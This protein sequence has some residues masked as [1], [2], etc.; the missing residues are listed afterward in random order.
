MKASQES[1]ISTSCSQFF[2][3]LFP[4][5]H[6]SEYS[7]SSDTGTL[8]PNSSDVPNTPSNNSKI[9]ESIGKEKTVNNPPSTTRITVTTVIATGTR[10]E[11]GR[12]QVQII[13]VY[14]F[15]LCLAF[16]LIDLKINIKQL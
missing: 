3:S 1:F 4:L 7:I 11:P 12:Q 8:R 10:M 9:T 6:V 14:E 13:T 5:P 16:W 15:G 2:I